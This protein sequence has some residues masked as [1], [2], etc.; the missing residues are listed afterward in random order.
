MTH[1][2]SECPDWFRCPQNHM[3][4]PEALESIDRAARAI[5]QRFA[6]RVEAE[7]LAVLTG[8]PGPA[9]RE[10]MANEVRNA[11]RAP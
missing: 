7:A 6:L 2:G 11:R 3:S 9:A 5:G 10:R 8:H 1:L 4:E